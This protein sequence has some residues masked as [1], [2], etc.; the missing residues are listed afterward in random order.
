MSI[1]LL[2]CEMSAIVWWFEHSLAL[3]FFGIGMKTEHISHDYTVKKHLDMLLLGLH[4][5]K[6]A[7]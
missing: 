4:A 6:I 5:W 3:S 1:A 7:F 2:A